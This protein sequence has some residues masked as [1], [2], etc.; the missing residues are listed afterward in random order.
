MKHRSV[1]YI[2]MVLAPLVF[3]FAFALDLYL[4]SIPVIKHQFHTSSAVVQL[5]MSLF[6]LALG[7][8]QLFWGPLSDRFGRQ[9]ISSISALIFTFASLCCALVDN[10]T[11]LIIFRMLQ[12]VGACGMMVVAYAIVRDCFSG[13]R[14]A[15]VIN[16]L[17]SCLLYTSPSPRD[18]RQ[19]RMPSSA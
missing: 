16:Y 13:D 17:N 7:V 6:M 10:I 12:A 5:T 19:S 9:C 4:P 11:L 8:G 15:R 1:G 2:V 14:S 3:S 18:K